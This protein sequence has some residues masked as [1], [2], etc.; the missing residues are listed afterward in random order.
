MFLNKKKIIKVQNNW[1]LIPLFG[2]IIF[3]FFYFLATLYYPGGSNFDGKSIGF[4]W[5][6][7]YWCDLTGK[8]AKN[9][10]T[11]EARNIAL[12]GMLILCFTL[13]L[14]WY[15]LPKFFH[16]SK[17]NQ[18]MIK[19]SGICAMFVLFFLFTT[20]HDSVIA[21]GGILSIIPLIG[22]FREL[23]KNKLTKLFFLGLLSL[24]LILLNYLIYMS[25]YFIFFRPVIQKIT[26]IVFLMW[27]FA[28]NLHCFL[29]EKVNCT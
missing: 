12:T 25:N 6:N 4:D 16:E 2:I 23:Y 14:F 28:I 27:I 10:K 21:L 8:Y 7:N 5:I 20:F 24:L 15:Y 13:S 3:I 26:F 11:N 17:F 9:G 19:Y 18:I 22:T 1:M 29:N